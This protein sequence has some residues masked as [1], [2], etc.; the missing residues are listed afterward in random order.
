MAMPFRRHDT[1][2][3]FVEIARY[4][5]LSAAAEAL[6]MTK[7]AVSYQVR[8]LEDE[9]QTTLLSREPRGITLTKQ[10]RALLEACRPGFEAL[11][12]SLH[13]FT[14]ARD[15]GLT[16]GLSSYFAARWL[17]PRLTGFMQRHPD[18]RLRLQPMTQLFDLEN[19]GIDIAIRWG[20]GQWDD[21]TVEPFLNMPAWPV[22][23]KAA[24]EKVARLGIEAAFAEFVLLRDH[25]DSN[26]WTDWRQEAGFETDPRRDTLI[27]PDPNVRVQA[28]ANGQGVALMD[29]L[30]AQELDDG[31]LVRLSEKELS[32]YGYFIVEPFGSRH[33]Q[34]VREF[35]DWLQGATHL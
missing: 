14:K 2:R 20:N 30:V 34:A 17:S 8:V 28:V 26:A 10:G 13:E 25:D 4:P 18:I 16:V 5:S 29:D 19:Q 24:L 31:C 7:G 27:I 3:L 35:S 22:G 15:V 9:L 21:A 23:N 32:D 1:L 11:E 6:N 33:S 12:T